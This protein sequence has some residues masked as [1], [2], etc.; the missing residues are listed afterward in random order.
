MLDID[1]K[2]WYII[3]IDRVLCCNILTSLYGFFENKF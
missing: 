3:D 2:L 1:V